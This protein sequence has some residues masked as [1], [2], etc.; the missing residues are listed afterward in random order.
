MPKIKKFFV[1]FLS[2]TILILSLSVTFALGQSRAASFEVPFTADFSGSDLIF[3]R[4]LDYD[5]VKLQG[6]RSY[7]TDLGKPWLP[8][9]ELK[10]A[11]PP[12]MKA[13]SIRLLQVDTEP[14]D[15]TYNILPSQ[16]PIEIG[17][18]IESL[19]VTKPDPELY[20]R[21]QIYPEQTVELAGQC[22]LAGQNMA[23]VR[24][25]P[26]R[27]NPVEKKLFLSRSISFVIEGTDGYTCGDYLPPVVSPEVRNEYETIVKSMVS[28]P[29]AVELSSRLALDKAAD[30]LPSG[31]YDHVIITS[32]TNAPY[33]T[34]LVNW[35]TRK[36]VPDTVILA[37][38]IYSAYSGADNQE[39]I[40]NF[41]IDAHNTWGTM[42]FLMGGENST[43]PFE[44]RTYDDESIPSDAYY[45]DYDDDWDYEV[46]VGRVTAEG[47]AQVNCFVEKLLKYETD[48]PLSDFPLEA[49]LVGMDLTL[50]A[51]PPYYTLTAGEEMKEYIDNYYI[52]TRFNVN[53]IYDSYPGEHKTT[54]I[55]AMNSGLNLI[56][57]CDH[58]NTT[59]MGIGYLNHGQ[60][61][62]NG[63]VDGFTNNNYPS[64]IFSLGCHPNEMDY[65][66]CIAEHF[67]IYNNLQGAVAFTGNTRSGWFYVGDPYS[68]SNQLDIYWWR[69]LFQQ[70]RFRLGETLAWAKNNNPANSDWFYVQWTLNLLGEPEMPVWTD[71]PQ[72]F[73]VSHATSIG[74]SDI[75]VTIHVEQSGGGNL[76][77]AYVCVW[78]GAE[79]YETGYTGSDGDVVFNLAALTQGN[80]LVTVTDQNYVPYQGSIEVTSPED[81]DGDGVLDNDDNCPTVYNPGQANSDGD[82][83]GDVC[84]NCP[85]TA[86]NDQLN[87]D[88]DD[89]GDACDNCPQTVN[90]DQLNADG[91][92]FGDACDKCPGFNDNFDS[93]HFCC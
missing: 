65:N 47:A 5:V 30:L 66:D 80:I 17:Q 89:F 6:G 12:G 77:N 79:L 31:R 70:N 49:A 29:E 75:S 27:Y 14:M 84:D 72:Q 36:G 34:P 48:P 9:R 74:V 16:K 60:L 93:S 62:T 50:A 45:G 28:N 69:G 88:G 13:V 32:A 25:F 68:L 82:A 2:S 21:S 35:H 3:D 90:D 23:R 44:Y 83:F 92:D 71:T 7:L 15:G 76:Q 24:L 38:D 91:D 42:Y 4:V 78:K 85:Q 39:K 73:A 18:S 19:E 41:V 40:R 63:D 37:A 61:L 81:A 56:N 8:V 22:D 86:N 57:H 58:S 64:V 33:Y 1:I 20:D 59:V 54:F 55:N 26:V 51:D 46:Y 52:P 67:V 87:A 53:K 11:L 43:V 10:I